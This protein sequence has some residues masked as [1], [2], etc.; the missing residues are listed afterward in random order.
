MNPAS[1][2]ARK[3]LF[4]SPTDEQKKQAKE[5]LERELNKDTEKNTE[6]WNFDFKTGTPLVGRFDWEKV[7]T[8][9]EATGK[10]DTDLKTFSE[11]TTMNKNNNHNQESKDQKAPLQ[12]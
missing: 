3:C 7:E 8:Q 12:K 9:T 5:D 1:G 11:S 6:K 2:R 4:G 10:G